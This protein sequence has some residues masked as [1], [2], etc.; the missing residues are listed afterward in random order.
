MKTSKK[1]WP[2][3]VSKNNDDLSF[4]ISKKLELQKFK[5]DWWEVLRN[6]RHLTGFLERTYSFFQECFEHC[7]KK[8]VEFCCKR[9]WKYVFS[10]E[11]RRFLQRENVDTTGENLLFDLMFFSVWEKQYELPDGKVITIGSERFRTP[12]VLFQPQFIGIL[13]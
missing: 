13:I 6:K 9:H 3:W 12:E 2:F 11:V 1:H 10:L 8:Y 5:S 7:R 4:Q